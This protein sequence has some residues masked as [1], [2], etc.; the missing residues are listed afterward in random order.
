MKDYEY[1]VKERKKEKDNA[2]VKIQTHDY[3]NYYKGLELQIVNLCIC[4]YS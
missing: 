3:V 4:S 2:N 1:N